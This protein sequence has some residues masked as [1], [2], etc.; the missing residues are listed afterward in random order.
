MTKAK[1]AKTMKSGMGG[2]SSMGPE[3]PVL[4]LMSA[5]PW[6][7]TQSDEFWRTAAT[8][9]ILVPRLQKAMDDM[10]MEGFAGQMSAEWLET[11]AANLKEFRQN[12]RGGYVEFESRVFFVCT[13][14]VN[15]FMSKK[16]VEEVDGSQVPLIKP[17]IDI[18]QLLA[19]N[20]ADDQGTKAK[21]SLAKFQSWHD[22][23][24]NDFTQ[25]DILAKL[26]DFREND[27]VDWALL[28]S[29]V[30]RLQGVALHEEFQ[31]CVSSMTCL[32][33]KKLIAEARETIVFEHIGHIDTALHTFD[34]AKFMQVFYYLTIRQFYF[35][36]IR[37]SLQTLDFET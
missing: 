4:E 1:K 2:P 30:E 34:V 11:A 9:K 6:W 31:A 17:L 29:W 14:K 28:Q 25:K 22:S 12:L 36:D 21:D 18:L 8:S 10:S 32:F 23:L 19:E 16:S 33:F 24:K 26:E 15:F 35:I 27:T 5:S 7:K 13:E 3:R 37:L 20:K